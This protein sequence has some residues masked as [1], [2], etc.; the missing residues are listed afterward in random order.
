VDAGLNA[1]SGAGKGDSTRKAR[2]VFS[3]VRSVPSPVVRL[4][5][6]LQLNARQAMDG[7]ELMRRLPDRCVT[8]AF[9][10]PQY[11]GILDK[12]SYGNEGEGR[13][14]ARC[15]LRQMP[16]ETIGAF[17]REIDRLLIPNGHLFLWM[18]KF[19][20]CTGF[21]QWIA[22]TKLD[23][24]DMITWN[25]GRMG[26]G[27][28][29]RRACEYLVVLQRPPRRAKG[30]WKAHDIPDVWCEKARTERGVHAK[31]VELQARLIEAVSSPGDLVLDP[32]AGSYSVLA[33]CLSIER[34]FIGCDL[35]D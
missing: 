14:K 24:V 4:P 20:V 27:Y 22:D 28:R 12:L 6:E 10:D 2:V 7:L 29:T 19:H 32:A 5:A 25:K 17:I 3:S 8:A 35:N 26:M 30:V 21:A 31:P 1:A 33:A 34:N 23:C 16:G 18:D 9:F 13:G 15:A 11:R